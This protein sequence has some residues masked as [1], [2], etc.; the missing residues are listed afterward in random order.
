MIMRSYHLMWLTTHPTL[1]D[2]YFLTE[3]TDYGEDSTM[4][5]NEWRPQT[6]GEWESFTLPG[7][8]ADLGRELKKDFMPVILSMC[9]N[10]KDE[11]LV[12]PLFCNLTVS[13]IPPITG[14]INILTTVFI[15][16]SFARRK[17]DSH[18]KGE[19]DDN[20]EDECCD[21]DKYYGIDDEECSEVFD[22]GDDE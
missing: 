21:V 17:T 5:G 14:F 18:E 10:E 16:H 15:T 7:C 12:Y 19:D 13:M 9:V 3:T 6:Y 8:V 4:L 2:H 11:K 1:K 22:S 20:E